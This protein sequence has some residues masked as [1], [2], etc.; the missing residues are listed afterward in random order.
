[1]SRYRRVRELTGESYY[2]NIDVYES[3]YYDRDG[4]HIEGKGLFDVL[5]S[6]ASSVATK[7]TGKAAKNIAQKGAEKL[8]EK[9][10]EAV[11]QKTG[12]LIGEKIYN[13]F[14]TPPPQHREPRSGG[15]QIYEELQKIN[16]KHTPQPTTPQKQRTAAELFDD[17][18]NM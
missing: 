12:Q 11:G 8:V 18:L 13:K 5:K 10:A 1:M 2:Y 6:T 16:A 17:I 4:R 14:S 9:G 7:L 3:G 15:L